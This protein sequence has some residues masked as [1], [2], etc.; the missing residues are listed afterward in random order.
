MTDVPRRLAVLF[1]VSVGAVVVTLGAVLAQV[2]GPVAAG[3][4]AVAVLAGLVVLVQLAKRRV[5]AARL[6]RGH[7]CDC[8]TGTIHDPIQ[9]I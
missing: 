9:V 4:Y 1:L 7:T 3:L 8:C 2:A 6:A 5:R